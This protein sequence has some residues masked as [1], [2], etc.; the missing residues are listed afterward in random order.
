MIN[1]K[2]NLRYKYDIRRGHYYLTEA[3]DSANNASN[4]GNASNITTDTDAD[5]NSNSTQQTQTVATDVNKSV[6]SNP[7][8]QK[9][10]VS[11]DAENKRYNDAL[12]TL[13]STYDTQKESLS[14]TL[15]T[16]LVTA[17]KLNTNSTYD[18]VQTNSDVLNIKQKI[19]DL[20]YKFVQDRTK[21]ENDHAKTIHDLEATRLQVLSKMNNEGLR[22]LPDKYLH[23]LNESNIHLAKIYINELIV[24]DEMHIM[25][26]MR[27]FKREFKDSSLVYGQDRQGYYVLCIDQ[28]DFNKLYAQLEK[29][30]YTRDEI[31][32]CIMP[33]ILDRSSMLDLGIN[34]QV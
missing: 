24:N 33:Q 2:S 20:D 29:V 28:E 11:V 1:R 17:G 31:F 27:D 3:D 12:S 23:F 18:N 26:D 14:Q 32:A 9:I 16:A 4:N 22:R 34:N 25:K 10:N 19:I 7:D 13:K 15:N 21:A 5:N 6:E 8:I 30:G